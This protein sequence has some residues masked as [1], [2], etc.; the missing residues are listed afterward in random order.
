MLPI[1]QNPLE[2]EEV[3]GTKPYVAQRGPYT[4]TS[5]RTSAF[6]MVYAA[7]IVAFMLFSLLKSVQLAVTLGHCG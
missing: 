4:S 6:S 3:P 5:I 2:L 1:Y 7:C